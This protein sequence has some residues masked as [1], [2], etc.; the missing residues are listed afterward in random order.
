M[1]IAV[2]IS[3]GVVL[4]VW[5]KLATV[6]GMPWFVG[7]IGWACYL[8][9]GGKIKGLTQVIAGG[10]AG[11]IVVAALDGGT[12]ILQQ[13]GLEWVALG[14]AALVVVL[15]AKLPLLSFIPAGLC[16]VAVLGAGGPMGLLDLT[17]N[18]KLALGFVVGAIA[19]FVADWVGSKMSKGRAPA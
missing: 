5:V 12:L 11:M 1:N 2:A 14:V 8:A 17:S 19:G 13:E 7:L 16:G 4:A 9:A 18:L 3:V 10:V 15:V 6:T